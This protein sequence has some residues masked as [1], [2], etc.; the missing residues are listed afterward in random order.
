VPDPRQPGTGENIPDSSGNTVGKRWFQALVPSAGSKRWFQAR[1][2]SRKATPPHPALLPSRKFELV[3]GWKLKAVGA[4]TP[5]IVARKASP[6]ALQRNPSASPAPDRHSGY[7][8]NWP[9]GSPVRVL[10]NRVTDEVRDHSLGNDP[11]A[12]PHEAIAE[13]EWGPIPKYSTVSRLRSTTGQL[14]KM[15]LYAGQSSALVHACESAREVI[16]R[17]LNE[18]LEVLDR[19]QAQRLT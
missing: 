4:S 19:L 7:A 2:L 15:A 17:M 13:D 12:L 1:T 5:S 3:S 18:A 6:T 8:I 10:R 11:Y 14:E 16:E 9:V